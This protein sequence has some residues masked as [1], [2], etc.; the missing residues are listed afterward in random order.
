MRGKTAREIR[1]MLKYH[2]RNHREYE[3]YLVPSV[4]WILQYNAETKK[5]KAVQ[6]EHES[7]L[8]ECVSEDRNLYKYFKRKYYNH[9]Y[10]MRLTQLPN[11]K[12]LNDILEAA[13]KE[14]TK[15]DSHE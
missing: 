5:V 15:E 4:K 9:D 2:P 13:V 12:A 7:R 11:K 1:K 10:E 6:R 14:A 3:V 8:L